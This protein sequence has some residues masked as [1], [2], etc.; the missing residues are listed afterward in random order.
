MGKN[1][2]YD[3]EWFLKIDDDTFFSPVNF[4]GYARY[5]NPEQP[6]YMG[7]TLMHLWQSRNIVFNAGGCYALSRESLRRVINIFESEAFLQPMKYRNFPWGGAF[8][9]AFFSPVEKHAFLGRSPLA[10]EEK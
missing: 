10:S 6:F 3:A 5:F 4:K 7:N 2:L 1:H 8:L 9:R